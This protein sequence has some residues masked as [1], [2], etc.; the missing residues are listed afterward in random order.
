MY[1]HTRLEGNESNVCRNTSFSYGLT[2]TVHL[3]DGHFILF[4]NQGVCGQAFPSFPSPTPFLPHFC[5]HPIFCV[6]RMRKTNTCGVNFVRFVR[7]HL[8]RRLYVVMCNG[9]KINVIKSSFIITARLFSYRV[10]PCV[11]VTLTM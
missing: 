4:Q 9:Y 6:S 3:L 1:Q 7:E 5:S 11:V 8:L 10:T 2:L